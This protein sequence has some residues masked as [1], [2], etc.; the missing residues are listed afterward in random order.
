M[1]PCRQLPLV[2]TFWVCVS[3]KSYKYT[4]CSG[5]IVFFLKNFHNFATSPSPAAIGC[6]EIGQIGPPKLVTVHSRCVESLQRYVWMDGLQW[7]MNKHNFSWTP[8]TNYQMS[9][10]VVHFRI[11]ENKSSIL[12]NSVSKDIEI[13]G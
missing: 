5:K 10:G 9:F 12:L 13:G 2:D 7:I 3:L 6:T 8:C 1:I 4:G 11:L